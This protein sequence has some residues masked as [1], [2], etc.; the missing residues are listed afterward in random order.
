MCLQRP[1]FLFPANFLHPILLGFQP[2][3][4]LPPSPLP[5]P[6]YCNIFCPTGSSLILWC[7]FLSASNPVVSP[8]VATMSVD[9]NLSDP[10]RVIVTS[11]KVSTCLIV[12]KCVCT[13]FHWVFVA[14]KKNK[15]KGWV[16]CELT[17][18]FLVIHVQK[19][20]PQTM[21]QVFWKHICNTFKTI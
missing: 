15:Q 14:K 16:L 17:F 21:H 8:R 2:P 10:V 5:S 7:I 12:V 19:Q 18:L 11:N 20:V 3:S 9:K 1:L 6:T 13:A 4:P